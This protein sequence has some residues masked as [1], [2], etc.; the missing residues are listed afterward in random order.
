MLGLAG[1]LAANGVVGL[2]ERNC[3][4]IM[5]YNPRRLYPLVDDK[6]ATKR[7]ALAAGLP[8]PE[9]YGVI[10]SHREVRDLPRLVASHRDFVVKPAQGSGGD[11]ILVV[12]ARVKDRNVYRLVDG[13]IL[14]EAAI[15]HHL[16]N[17][18]SGQYSLGGHRD[19]ALVEYCVKFDATFAEHSFRGVPDIRVIVFRGYPAMAMVRL[20]T[21]RS[22]GKANL[23]QG[24]VGAGID[25][26]TG[27]T[28]F[29]VTG[30][31][32]VTEHP[33]TGAPIAG[34]QIPQWEYLLEFA[35]R[36]YELTGLGYLGVDIV[37]DRDKGPMLLE[38]NARPGLNIQIANRSGLKPRLDRVEA[39]PAG[40]SVAERVAFAMHSLAGASPVPA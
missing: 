34:L 15:E 40:A 9:L 28:N 19:V 23:H 29:G 20:P 24:A 16:S 37:L 2:N 5:R 26:A 22:H 27:L 10:G 18:I 3:E 7:L 8:V 30:N 38:L 4:Y 6:L 25:L 11:G 12:S 1:K 33:D 35:A 14:D 17:I 32:T 31:T 21:R 13:S 39:R 36:C